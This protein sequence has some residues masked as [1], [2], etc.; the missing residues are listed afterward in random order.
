MKV[1]HGS[2]NIVRSP[3]LDK[4]KPNNDYGRGFYT[5]ESS[6]LAKEWAAQKNTAGFINEYELHLEG[7]KILDLTD[8]QYSVLHWV[9]LLL[10]NR[11]FNLNS[12]VLVSYKKAFLD[13][14]LIEISQFDVVIGYRA[15]DS[16]FSYASSFV[17][18]SIPLRLLSRAVEL[19]DLG[20][21]I[22]L[23]SRKAFYQLKFISYQPVD[24]SE[25]YQKFL[26]RDFKARN[27]YK[28][29]VG[30]LKIRNNYIF[31]LDLIRGDKK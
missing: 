14:Y 11:T 28:K 13:K 27:N 20:T 15:D 5:T 21:Q 9:A 6:E 17:E 16:Y 3:S 18:N 29:M 7:L 25:Y 12:S 4:G 19:G 23:V 10:N 24:K 30:N 8:E 22:V 1:F 26:S 31:I 2:T